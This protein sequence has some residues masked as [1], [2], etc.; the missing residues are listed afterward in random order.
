VREAL[1]ISRVSKFVYHLI[2]KDTP[3]GCYK[4]EFMAPHP[5][6]EA[7]AYVD[8]G[9]WRLYQVVYHSHREG[10]D[11]QTKNQVSRWKKVAL[12]DSLED[13]IK[14]VEEK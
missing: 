9:K 10:R 7:G 5:D 13:C 4:A 12:C 6:P 8:E 14:Y 2:K 1:V 11:I 3:T